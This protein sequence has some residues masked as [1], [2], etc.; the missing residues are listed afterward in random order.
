MASE[1]PENHQR[2][3]SRHVLCGSGVLIPKGLQYRS[4]VS[5]FKSR[6]SGHPNPKRVSGLFWPRKEVSWRTGAK[7]GVVKAHQAVGKQS[8]HCFSWNYHVVKSWTKCLTWQLEVTCH[9]LE[10]QSSE[11]QTSEFLCTSRNP[12]VYHHLFESLSSY[13]FYFGFL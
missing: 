5:H 12:E 8:V 7:A 1:A 10:T 4:V 9:K 11:I 6:G 3:G 13:C 2:T